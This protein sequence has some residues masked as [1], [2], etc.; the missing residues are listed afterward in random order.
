[1]AKLRN[2]T[3]WTLRTE[4]DGRAYTTEP[5]GVL[6]VPDGVFHDMV[7]PEE[8]W[9]EVETPKAHHPRKAAAPKE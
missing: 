5:D 2:I 8:T 7:F 9:A 6:E 3:N 1:M 4:L